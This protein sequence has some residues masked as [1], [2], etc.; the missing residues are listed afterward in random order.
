[1][2]TTDWR[3]VVCDPEVDIVVEADRRHR[4]RRSHIIEE[5]LRERKSVVTANKELMALRGAELWDLANQNGVNLAMEASVAGGIPIHT[6]LREGIAGDRVVELY[7]IL[8]GTSNFILTEIEKSNAAFESVLGRG[9]AAGICGSRSIGR[10]RW[11]GCAFEA[12]DSGGACFRRKAD[13]GGYLHRRHPAH[14]A[15]GFRVCASAETH[16]PAALSGAADRRRAVALGAAQPD[17]A[18]GDSGAGERRL[19]RHLDSRRVWRRYVLLRP[20]RRVRS[21]PA[22]RWSAI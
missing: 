11:S 13:A 1:M 17:S 4:Q 6:V 18:I 8:N 7:G 5:A 2:R 21:R 10:C 20:R 14:D 22:W 9:A 3:E 12:G 15:G 16:H 19:Q